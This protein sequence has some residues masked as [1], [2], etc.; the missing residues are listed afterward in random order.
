MAKFDPG[1]SV[2]LLGGE[3]LMTVVEYSEQRHE[4]K[5]SWHDEMDHSTWIPEGI[6]RDAHNDVQPSPK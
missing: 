6:L 1:T 4:V 5:C 2:K 3:Q